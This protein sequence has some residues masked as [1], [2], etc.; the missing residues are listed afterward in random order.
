[1]LAGFR[2]ERHLIGVTKRIKTIF[3]NSA[4]P[5]PVSG[6][7]EQKAAHARFIPSDLLNDAGE[8]GMDGSGRT[9]SLV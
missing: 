9:R 3:Q 1:M 2:Q 7:T 6:L 4:L 5:F 8:D